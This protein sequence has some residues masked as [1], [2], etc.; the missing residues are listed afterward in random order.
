MTTTDTHEL[1]IPSDD[2]INRPSIK[3]AFRPVR[4]G[5]IRG[6]IFAMLASAI[7][8]GCLNLPIRV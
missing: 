8:T 4:N 1:L 6:S 7:A 3:G 5:N 2:H